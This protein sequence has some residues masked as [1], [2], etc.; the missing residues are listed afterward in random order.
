MTIM[1]H[2]GIGHEDGYIFLQKKIRFTNLEVK[3]GGHVLSHP[4]PFP[5]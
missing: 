2:N 5:F 3:S 1:I 4:F